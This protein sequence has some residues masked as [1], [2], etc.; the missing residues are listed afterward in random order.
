MPTVTVF[1]YGF[2]NVRSAVRALEHV[3]AEV[4]LTSDRDTAENA[5][6]LL[7]PG[8]GAFAACMEGLRAKRGD[9]IV[10]RRL[11]GGRPVLGICVGM[12]ILFAHGVEFGVD[13]AGC[14]QWP[15]AVTRL[16]APVIPHMGWNTVAAAP[17]STLFA[18][19]DADTRFYFVH[20]YAAQRWEGRP[21]ALVTR[22]T[23][24]VPF[25]AAVED[26]PLAATQL[27]PEKSGDAGATLLSN[28]VEAL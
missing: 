12:Q 7:V 5:D 20:S 26:G 14:G 4:T 15:G 24:R 27:H 19:L 17:G 18:G 1:D 13:T 11:S 21:E 22:A 6:G 28:W 25:L 23:H 10:E 16:D 8:V 3:E 9:Q 2:G